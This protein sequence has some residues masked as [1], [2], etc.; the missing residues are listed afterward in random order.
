MKLDYRITFN[1]C[2]DSSRLEIILS[3][4]LSSNRICSHEPT[5]ANG[6]STVTHEPDTDGVKK[7]I[8]K[9]VDL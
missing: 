1:L 9:L 7:V 4:K 5:Y 8:A 6:L 3:I 2:A